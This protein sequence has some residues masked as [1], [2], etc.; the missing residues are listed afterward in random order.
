MDHVVSFYDRKNVDR[1]H[2]D[3]VEMYAKTSAGR[4]Y[5]VWYQRHLQKCLK[6]KHLKTL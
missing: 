5:G 6:I 3:R 2:L 1:N 4:Q